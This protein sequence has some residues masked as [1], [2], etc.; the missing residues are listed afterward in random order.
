[1]AI[2]T[3]PTIIKERY[4]SNQL[5][6]VEDFERERDYH[7]SER[8]L[9]AGALWEAGILFDLAVSTIVNDNTGAVQISTGVALNAAGKLIP[10][11][12][13][14]SFAGQEVIVQSNV[15]TIHAGTTDY[16]GKTWILSIEPNEE[17]IPLTDNQL[18]SVPLLSLTEEGSS[19]T[20]GQIPLARLTV[21][22]VDGSAPAAYT[23]DIDTSV[24]KQV[25]LQDGR[26]DALDAGMI[27]SGVLD[28]ARIPK[29]SADQID[30]GQFAVE[31][32]PGLDADRIVSGTLSPDRIPTLPADKISGLTGSEL[33]TYWAQSV[34][35]VPHGSGLKAYPLAAGKEEGTVIGL[36]HTVTDKGNVY[37]SMG[38]GFPQTLVS[39]ASNELMFSGL[40]CNVYSDRLQYNLAAEGGT[41]EE[42][43]TGLTFTGVSEALQFSLLTPESELPPEHRN[44][45][46]G[47]VTY[48]TQRYQGSVTP[49]IGIGE[50]VANI[51]DAVSPFQYWAAANPSFSLPTVE[52]LAQ[53]LKNNGL[54]APDA[55]P[56]LAGQQPSLHANALSFIELLVKVFP[57]SAAQPA[58]VAWSLSAARISAA[59]ASAALG[60]FYKGKISMQDFITLTIGSFPA[61]PVEQVVLQLQQQGKTAQEAV[62]TI[63]ESNSQFD[64]QPVQLGIL[65]RV[66]FTDSS[67]TPLLMAQAFFNAGYKDKEA[68]S[69]A[70]ATLFPQSASND[71]RNAIDSAFN[72]S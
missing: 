13:R 9:L 56:I 72:K 3:V 29:L 2:T 54:I 51:R 10:L 67:N 20:P 65:L 31:R 50:I 28:V 45:I 34:A 23:L 60:V 27:Q 26:L 61:P 40:K 36:L 15:V 21:H 33:T 19:L 32:L 7:V 39:F 37:Y 69:A 62:A 57:E 25:T 42:T 58:Q 47:L 24:R 22:A 41:A 66:Y 14:A 11:S 53:Q 16:A 64:T 44:K 5:L 68:L 17:P 70:L 71:I 30:S 1:M 4:Y 63:K 8:E 18:Q 43:V 52:A 59:R 6:G 55:A 48:G 46:I 35:V 49:T 12:N 38:I